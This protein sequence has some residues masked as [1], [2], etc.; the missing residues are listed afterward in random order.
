MNLDGLQMRCAAWMLRGPIQ[1]PVETLT[2]AE[3]ASGTSAVYPLLEVRARV[4]YCKGGSPK[5]RRQNNAC[6]ENKISTSW[7]NEVKAVEVV[8]R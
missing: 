4:L 2:L 7:L 6:L 1:S 8:C 3:V 5:K